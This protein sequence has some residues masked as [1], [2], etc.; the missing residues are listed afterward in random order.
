MIKSRRRRNAPLPGT[1][2]LKALE[3]ISSAIFRFRARLSPLEGAGFE[4]AVPQKRKLAR[5]RAVN[6]LHAF[7]LGIPLRLRLL[8]ET[9]PRQEGGHEQLS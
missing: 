3:Q 4:L 9:M 2:E 7:N 5:K 6:C 1:E 8:G